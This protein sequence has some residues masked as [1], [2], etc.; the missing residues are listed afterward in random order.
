MTPAAIKLPG[1]HRVKMRLA[2]DRVGI[3]WYRRRGGPLLMKF[4]GDTLGDALRAEIAGQQDLIDAYASPTARPEPSVITV[5]EIVTRFKAAPD[6]YLSLRDSTRKVWAPML[7]RVVDEFGDLPARALNA[8]GMRRAIID[9]RDRYAATPRS[10]DYGVQVLKRVLNFGVDREL[11]ETNPALGV[12]AIYKNN[13]ADQIVEPE[14]LTAILAHLSPAARLAV[15]LSAATGMRRGDLIDLRWSEVSDFSIERA[16]GKSTNGVRIMVPL[17]REARDVLAELRQIRD[18]AKVAST[19]V[20][21]SRK[22]PWHAD[23]LTSLFVR[24][25]AKAGVKKSLHD[26]RGTAATRF[27]IAGLKDEEIADIFGW[28]PDRVRKIRVRYVDRARVA[29]GIITRLERRGENG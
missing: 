9:W 18:S 24:A 4:T 6:G 28:E 22:G 2:G 5:R 29:Q 14:E 21:T 17:I 10:A 26:L 20:L 23:G 12:G 1:A 8:K 3:Y 16:A 13:R 27:V 25:A 19:F 7:D 15:R 11:C